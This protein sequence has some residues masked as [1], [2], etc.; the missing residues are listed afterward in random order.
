MDF[1]ALISSGMNEE[2]IAK[3][4]T[5][6]QNKYGIIHHNE[7]G[8]ALKIKLDRSDMVDMLRCIQIIVDSTRK[9]EKAVTHLAE[10]D[11]A[12]VAEHILHLM[13]PNPLKRI[14]KKR[15][16]YLQDTECGYRDG[17]TSPHRSAEIINLTKFCN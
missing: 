3:V 12:I 11:L 7:E 4:E 5:S 6:T 15:R 1:R 10:M 14:S 9:T 17:R 2:V 16:L 8:T 13:S